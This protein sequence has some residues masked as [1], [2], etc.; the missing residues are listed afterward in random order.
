MHTHGTLQATRSTDRSSICV[1]HLAYEDNARYEWPIY[2]LLRWRVWL[3]SDSFSSRRASER[4]GSDAI[5]ALICMRGGGGAAWSAQRYIS[6]YVFARGAR[7]RLSNRC[8]LQEL[9]SY[10]ERPFDLTLRTSYKCCEPYSSKS[11]QAVRGRART[12]TWRA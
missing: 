1:R 9:Y 6:S 5:L 3:D 8:L 2:F 11:I 4:G 7:L 12:R 10:R